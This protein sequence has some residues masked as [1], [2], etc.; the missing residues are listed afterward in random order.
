MINQ[1]RCKIAQYCDYNG[2]NVVVTD[3]GKGDRTDFILSP[4]AFSNLG[5]NKAASEALKKYG[6]LEFEYKRVPCTFKGNNILFQI[7]EH[8]S[9][10][11]YFAITIL[12]VGGKTDVTA[13][14]MLRKEQRKWEPLRRS[15]GAVF[16]IANPP[17]GQIRLKFQVNGN[18]GLQWVQPK[19]AIPA[20]WKA[21]ATYSANL[22]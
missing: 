18:A 22:A 19:F 17:R 14:E 12:Y 13:V 7:N 1:V 6:V 8:S 21:G 2:V 16:D 15:Y 3:Y 9:N 5:R 20:N 11:G 10:P 4:R